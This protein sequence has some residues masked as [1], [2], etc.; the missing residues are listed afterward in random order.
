MGG[1]TYNYQYDA[2]GIRTR[3]TNFD[4]GYTE[5]YVVEG[6]AVAEER[7]RANG[8]KQ[9]TLRYLYDESNS[10]VGFGI[11][12]ATSSPYWQYYYFGKNIQGD[13]IALYRSDYN[14][15]SQSYY[16]TLVATYSYDPWG[17]PTGIYDANGNA[18]SQTAYHL[19][20][21]NPFRYRG[22]RYDGDTRLYYLQSRYYDPAIGRFINADGHVSTGQEYN[23]Y[24]MFACCNNNPVM[25]MDGDGK[26]ATVAII[27][28]V[29]AAVLTGFFT[30]LDGGSP[31]EIISKSLQVGA[32]AGLS[33]FTGSVYGTVFAKVTSA[34][35]GAAA[36]NIVL[37]DSNSKMNWKSFGI[38]VACS[39]IT[40]G[41]FNALEFYNPALDSASTAMGGV[42]VD[43]AKSTMETANS[44]FKADAPRPSGRHSGARPRL[45]PITKRQRLRVLQR[46]SRRAHSKQSVV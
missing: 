34:A 21:Y 25:L 32:I 37:Q 46:R 39:A 9:Y 17:T 35:V 36:T 14:S 7:F 28:I 16:P 42:G 26:S 31:G 44:V 43:L 33:L 20:V 30:Y 15:S 12:Y 41:V 24:N 13:V 40:E 10:P 1:V 45:R 23:G 2:S 19:A 29:G 5:Y 4:G 22:Y 18:I 6:L 3:K 38:D 27:V 8:T 11:R